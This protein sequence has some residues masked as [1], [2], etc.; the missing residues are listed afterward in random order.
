MLVNIA[1]HEYSNNSFCSYLLLRAACSHL[2]EKKLGAKLPK[3]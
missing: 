3:R 2:Q 1:A